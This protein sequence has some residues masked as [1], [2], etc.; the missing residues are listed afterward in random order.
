MTDVS[1]VDDCIV[2]VTVAKVRT[3]VDEYDTDSTTFLTEMT[4]ILPQLRFLDPG[5]QFAPIFAR[6]PKVR[7]H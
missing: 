5:D 3:Y 4:K 7:L 2:E 6:I 1:F